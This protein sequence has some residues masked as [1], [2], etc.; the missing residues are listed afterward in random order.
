MADDDD[1]FG[2][3][4]ADDDE[5]E[6]QEIMMGH[7]IPYQPSSRSA[8]PL[9]T[10]E[11]EDA[12]LP[13]PARL[14]AEATLRRPA[15]QDLPRLDTSVGGKT[16]S[17]PARAAT[18]SQEALPKE[19]GVQARGGVIDRERPRPSSFFGVDGQHNYH[20]SSLS[21]GFG[22]SSSE[23][24]GQLPRS[25]TASSGELYQ[26]G[27]GN[28]HPLARRSSFY[29]D[30]GPDEIPHFRRPSVANSDGGLPNKRSTFLPGARSHP[31][32]IYGS[33]IEPHSAPPLLDHSHLKPGASASLLSHAK[34]LELYRVNAKKTNDPDVAF[35]FAVLLMEHAREQSAN[36]PT[37]PSASPVP[38]SAGDVTPASA[39]EPQNASSRLS[40]GRKAGKERE[41]EP[42]PASSTASLDH[43]L[44]ARHIGNSPHMVE[45]ITILKRIA[46]RG[47]VGA[48][49]LLGESYAQ[50]IGTGPKC[51]PDHDKAFGLFVLAGKH[52]HAESCFRVGHCCEHGLGCRK[53]VGKAVTWYKYVRPAQID[54][55]TWTD[56]LRTAKRQRFNTPAPCTDSASQDSTASSPST[57]SKRKASNGSNAPPNSLTNNPNPLRSKLCTSSLSYT[58]EAS[59]TSSL[60]ISSMRRNCWPK[61][62]NWVMRRART[63]WASVMSTA[64]WAVRRIRRSLFITTVRVRSL[65]R[66]GA[67]DRTDIAAQQGHREAC[68]A[69]TAWYLVGSP[70]V[71]PQSDTEAYLWAKKAAEQGLA[72]AEYAVGYVFSL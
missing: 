12:A 7:A 63:S 25:R 72:K 41:P 37:P 66:D 52:G 49:A 28:D 44:D 62:A 38:P 3:A 2:G 32:S 9:S 18:A 16:F 31:P 57:A 30:A 47:H 5:E 64:R 40:I 71:L 60:S 23:S 51:R 58:N 15:S 6:E 45:A 33:P 48:Q 19:P 20:A 61:R 42:S 24:T 46:D 10:G 11:P 4:A 65:L 26:Q 36:I 8:T 1:F 50:G 59:S 13:V 56:L 14:T 17:F 55:G 67:D 69:L 29:G 22:H 53:D 34:T 43:H 68:F 39:I 21:N 27:E 54:I 35:E 70:G